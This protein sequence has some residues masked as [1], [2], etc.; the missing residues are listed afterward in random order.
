MRQPL[1]LTFATLLA[2]CL[3]HFV[4]AEN[5][6]KKFD[7]YEVHYSVFNSSFLTPEVADAYNIVRSKSSAVMNISVLQKQKDG[8]MKSVSAIVTGEQY[9][10]I[11]HDPLDFFEVRE[12]GTRYYLNSFD[13][14]HK[15]SI[16]FTVFIQVSP[17]REPYKLQFNKLLYKD[18]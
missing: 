12:Q 5:N 11:R 8:S 18:E 4:C 2:L 13:I 7:D 14:T 6:V 9:D 3:S 1:K 10:L 16:Y 15:T 17:N